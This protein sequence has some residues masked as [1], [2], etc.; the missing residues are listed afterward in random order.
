MTFFF[1]FQEVKNNIDLDHAYMLFYER[2]DLDYTRFIPNHKGAAPELP[3]ID[4]EI[5]DNFRKLCVIQWLIGR[6][7]LG[8]WVGSVLYWALV[9]FNGSRDAA[10]NEIYAADEQE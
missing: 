4:D 7:K 1:S 8:S 3:P 9:S 5:E 6:G 10:K 2:D